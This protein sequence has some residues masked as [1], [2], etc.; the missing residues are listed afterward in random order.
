MWTI[1]TKEKM[2]FLSSF[3]TRGKPSCPDSCAHSLRPALDAAQ[4]LT[5]SYLAS[6][7]GLSFPLE[8]MS[9]RPVL[10]GWQQEL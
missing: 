8:T 2:S 10:E 1:V 9:S 7:E 5:L 6:V 4:E 3:L